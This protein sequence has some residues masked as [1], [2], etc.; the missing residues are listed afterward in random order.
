MNVRLRFSMFYEMFLLTIGTILFL[1]IFYQNLHCNE[2][3]FEELFYIAVSFN[4]LKIHYLCYLKPHQF[5]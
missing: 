1:K 3:L 5:I 2:I 4:C